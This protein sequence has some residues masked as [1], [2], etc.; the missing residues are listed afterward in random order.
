MEENEASEIRR[1][2]LNAYCV[3]RGWVSQKDSS[4]GSPSELKRMLGKGVAFW[5]NLLRDSNKSFGPTLAREIEKNLGLPKYFLEGEVIQPKQSNIV[6][7]DQ[8]KKSGNATNVLGKES[9]IAPINIKS[10]G[11]PVP[12]ITFAQVANWNTIPYPYSPDISDEWFPCPIP[13][14]PRTYCIEIVSDSMSNPGSKPSYDPG[15]IIFID[16]DKVPVSGDRVAVIFENE[17]EA[18][19]RQYIEDG[20]KKYLKA[21]NPKWDQTY[22]EVKGKTTICGVVLAKLVIG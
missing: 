20:G 17:A 12:L 14:G 22:V 16:P 13:H 7:P 11:R 18:T 19:F 2:N 3:K 9:N 1:K 4:K 15:D 6:P 10:L 5:S 21:L 8:T